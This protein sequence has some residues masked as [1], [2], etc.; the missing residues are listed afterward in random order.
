MKF[1]RGFDSLR[2]IAISFVLLTHLGLYIY[3]P[4]NDLFQIRVWKLISGGTGVQL[5]FTLSGFLITLIVLAEKSK[6]S[7]VNFKN[8]YARRF[9]RLLPPLLIFYITIAILMKLGMI[10]TTAF[11]LLLSF[12]YLY[13]FVPYLHYTRELG[14]T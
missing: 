8:F 9:L 12:F 7:R 1:I 4:D 11:G 13:N 3:L 6:F 2:G 5:F 14:H 10:Q